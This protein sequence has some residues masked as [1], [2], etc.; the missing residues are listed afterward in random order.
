MRSSQ[1]QCN[2]VL[3]LIMGPRASWNA[4]CERKLAVRYQSPSY[5]RSPKRWWSNIWAYC[6]HFSPTRS[7]PALFSSDFS[8]IIVD[9]KNL[10]HWT[11]SKFK[12]GRN[13]CCRVIVDMVQVQH[14]LEHDHASS[15]PLS[16]YLH[17]VRGIGC[18]FEIDYIFSGL[19]FMKR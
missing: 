6:L 17:P 3:F 9:S 15:E 7:I 2:A 4:Q 12:G 14:D 10:A 16:Q 19:G 18:S 13:C 5:N 8:S 11:R 1:L